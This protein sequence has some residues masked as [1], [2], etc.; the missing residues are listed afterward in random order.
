MA[1]E[2]Q[3]LDAPEH[4]SVIELHAY[5]ERKRGDREMPDRAD[6]DPAEIV[7][8]LPNIIIA[9]AINGGEDFRTR[10]FGTALVELLGEERTGKLLSEFGEESSLSTDPEAVQRRWLHIS[11]RAFTGRKPVFVRVPFAASDRLYLVG[12]AISAPLTA[13]GTEPAQTIGA[14]FVVHTDRQPGL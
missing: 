13:G 11:R 14:M 9:E 3:F 1:E 10:L 5:L 12:H 8:F 6:I 7:R 4:P 2:P